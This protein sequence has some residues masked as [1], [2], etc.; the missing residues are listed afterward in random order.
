[1]VDSL[2]KYVNIRDQIKQQSEI[3]DVVYEDTWNILYYLYMDDEVVYIGQRG[4]IYRSK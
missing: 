4:S 2:I 1:M 3:V